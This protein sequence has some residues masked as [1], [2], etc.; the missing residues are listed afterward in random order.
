MGRATRRTCRHHI[1]VSAPSLRFFS[2]PGHEAC[3]YRGMATTPLP[4]LYIEM[5]LL[6]AKS[7]ADLELHDSADAVLLY[8]NLYRRLGLGHPDQAAES[9]E[10]WQY[11]STLIGLNSIDEQVAWT[12][13]FAADLKPAPRRHQDSII[14][15]PFF[16]EVVGEL[17][18]THFAPVTGDETSPL[19][20]SKRD[21]LRRDLRKVVAAARAAHPE[22]RRV[23]GTS[24]LYTTEGYRSL[25][26][27][28][29]IATARVRTGVFRFQGS[30][31]WGQF[32]DH[33][34]EVKPK[35]R[36]QFLA[37]LEHFDG[38]EPWLLFPRPTIVVDSPIEVFDD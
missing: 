24:W 10:W 9:Q 34:G 23:R 12:R 3:Q 37:D 31:S 35:L 36:D 38:S 14:S 27:P 2:A 13:T 22:I 17:L 18:R 15:G 32:L 33:R 28:A 5:Q 6:L 11:V 1:R 26:P 21:D 25:F 29:H 19:H 8:T 30:S 20:P 16:A 7:V 4:R